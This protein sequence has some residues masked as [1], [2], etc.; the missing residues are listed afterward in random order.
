MSDTFWFVRTVLKAKAPQI[1]FRGAF[2]LNT[3]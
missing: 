3:Y 2:G 1:Y